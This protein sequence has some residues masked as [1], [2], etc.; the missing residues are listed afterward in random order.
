MK[1]SYLVMIVILGMVISYGLC[2]AATVKDKMDFKGPLTLSGAIQGSSALT[3]E[4]A[5]KDDYKTTVAVTDPTGSRTVTIPDGTGRLPIECIASHDYGDT[6]ID[7]TMTTAEAQCSH[8]V[9]LNA[10]GAVSAILP[11]AY[12]GKTRTVVNSSGQA[13]TLKVT[14][15]TGSAVASGKNAVFADYTTDV[16]KII[17]QP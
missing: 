5:T 1:R 15:K 9:F 14:G 4:G 10:S 3:F 17:E 7:W 13:V 2:S 12:P 16:T 11:R 8:V 6:V